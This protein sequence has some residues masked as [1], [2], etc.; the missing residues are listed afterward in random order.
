M[1]TKQAVQLPWTLSSTIFL[2]AAWN[3][4]TEISD[5]RKRAGGGGGSKIKS[6]AAEER[7]GLKTELCEYLISLPVLL[8][9][10]G[11]E[12]WVSMDHK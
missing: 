2:S 1:R 8:Q 3:T 10:F 4:A 9:C 12:H 7:W 11:G 5:V 6:I